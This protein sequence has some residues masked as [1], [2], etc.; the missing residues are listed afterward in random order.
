MLLLGVLLALSLVTIVAVLVSCEAQARAIGGSL[1]EL[2]LPSSEQAR[3]EAIVAPL[4][5]DPE[6]GRNVR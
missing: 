4:L 1:Q 2:R 3:F 6:F 5:A